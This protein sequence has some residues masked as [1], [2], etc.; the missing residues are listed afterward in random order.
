MW[1]VDFFKHVVVSGSFTLPERIRQLPLEHLI[2]KV[3]G[4]KPVLSGA[5]SFKLG[6]SPDELFKCNV[7]VTEKA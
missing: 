7:I 4:N 6:K 2:V 5:E 1:M 3:L